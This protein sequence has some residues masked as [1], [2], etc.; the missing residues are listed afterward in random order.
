MRIFD[1]VSIELKRGP[2]VGMTKLTLCDLW[3]SAAFEE[4][5]GVHV[6]EGVEAACPIVRNI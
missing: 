1:K 5:T 6:P 3:R 4:E 2:C